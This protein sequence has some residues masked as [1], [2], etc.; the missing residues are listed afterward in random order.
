MERGKKEVP[1]SS[2]FSF[3]ILF[4]D[5]LFSLVTTETFLQHKML[6]DVKL[7]KKKNWKEEKFCTSLKQDLVLN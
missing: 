1:T 3:I 4:A 7:S 2:T 5:Y 6:L